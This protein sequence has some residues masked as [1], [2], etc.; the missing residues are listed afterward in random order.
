MTAI[1]IRN[2]NIEIRNNSKI[3][4]FKIQ[5]FFCLG[6]LEFWT[7]VFISNFG[8]RASYLRLTIA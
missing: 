6:E 3:L 4:I 2:P 5:N 7:F 8:F 1:E